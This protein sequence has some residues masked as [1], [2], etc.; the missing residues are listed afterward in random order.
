M[1]ECSFFMEDTSSRTLDVTR[2]VFCQKIAIF[3]SILVEQKWIVCAHECQVTGC[4]KPSIVLEV[5]IGV[6]ADVYISPSL[7]HTNLALIDVTTVPT[8]TFS[9]MWMGLKVS[10]SH[11]GGLLFRS[12][13]SSSMST[14]AWEGGYP[15]SDARTRNLYLSLCESEID[16]RHGHE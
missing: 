7:F 14:S 1:P 8:V 2:G 9:L 6:E 4:S 15:R 16:K 12:T 10:L 11:S 3:Q 5:S 13:T